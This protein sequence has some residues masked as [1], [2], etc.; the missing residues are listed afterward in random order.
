MVG[1]NKSAQLLHGWLNSEQ[2]IAKLSSSGLDKPVHSSGSL[3]PEK[4]NTGKKKVP[5]PP[6]V[7]NSS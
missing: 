6:L 4:T 7:R 2:A 5:S 3:K 1:D